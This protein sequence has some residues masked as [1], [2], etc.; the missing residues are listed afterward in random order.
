MLLVC[1]LCVIY[2]TTSAALQCQWQNDPFALINL[3]IYWLTNWVISQRRRRWI[4]PRPQATRVKLWLRS[5]MWFSRYASGQTDKLN[6]GHRSQHVES[7]NVGRAD[8]CYRPLR[9]W[10]TFTRH[11]RTTGQTDICVHFTRVD[12]KRPWKCAAVIC[13]WSFGDTWKSPSTVQK[14]RPHTR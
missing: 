2:F 3:L 12:I 6:T 9:H 14:Q 4:E 1:L 7:G 13:S 8:H 11:N 5:A 10:T